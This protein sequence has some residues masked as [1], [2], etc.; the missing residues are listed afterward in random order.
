MSE[1]DELHASL[2]RTNAKCFSLETLCL[3]LFKHHPNRDKVIEH[4]L[5]MKER[6]A[7]KALNDPI[8]IDPVPAE[9]DAAHEHIYA[10]LKTL[11]Q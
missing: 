11:N 1:I 5:E 2:L 6:F 8:L 3:S 4:F 7:A 9:M 10:V